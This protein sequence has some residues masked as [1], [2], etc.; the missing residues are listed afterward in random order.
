MAD[1]LR[2]G[3]TLRAISG[4]ITVSVTP[5]TDPDAIGYSLLTRGQP[6]DSAQGFP[7]CRAT[8]TYPAEGYAAVLGWTQM[9]RSTDSATG[10]F[11]M[12]P[13][14]LY[15]QIPTPYAFFG[16]K[17]E[18]FDAPSRGARYDMDWE[19]HS[20]LCVSP[21]A[22]ITRH[23]QAIAG[24][25][26]GF[27]ITDGGIAFARPAALGPADWDSHLDLLRTDYPGWTFDNGYPP[28]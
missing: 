6:T 11:A 21:D 20:F 5:N 14:A 9:V 15:Q 22:V 27:T 4:L 18:L 26:W 3:F 1:D 7:V 2:I 28:V 13:I 12:D 19:A 8:L 10:R 23:V 16:V 24:F 17:P 25:N